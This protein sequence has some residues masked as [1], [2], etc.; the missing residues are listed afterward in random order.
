MAHSSYDREGLASEIGLVSWV[1]QSSNDFTDTQ[2]AGTCTGTAAVVMANILRLAD[3]ASM[4]VSL[5]EVGSE[6]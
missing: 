1:M 3:A 4:T 6:I 2:P 5:T